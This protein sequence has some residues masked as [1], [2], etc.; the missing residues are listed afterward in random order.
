[1]T[2]EYKSAHMTNTSYNTNINKEQ[3][4]VNVAGEVATRMKLT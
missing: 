3:A 1:M 4:E 2:T